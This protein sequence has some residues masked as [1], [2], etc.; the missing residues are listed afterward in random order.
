MNP[1]V[2]GVELGTD[3]LDRELPAD[4]DALGTALL[5]QMKDGRAQLLNGRDRLMEAGSGQGREFAL[6][7]IQPVRS[8]R[9]VEEL[10]ALRQ[11]ERL[12]GRKMV[13]KGA[14]RVRIQIVLNQAE[15]DCLRIGFGQRLAELGVLAPGS[16]P[17]HLTKSAACQGLNRSE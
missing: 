13:V 1:L 4:L 6:N 2:V 5:E 15:L 8:L 7:H 3:R 12:L 17:A 10:K 11:S 14:T 16:L 9:R